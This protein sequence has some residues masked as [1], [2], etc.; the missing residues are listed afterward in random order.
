MLVDTGKKEQDRMYLA[1]GGIAKDGYTKCPFCCHELV[2][3]PQVRNGL[4]HE[5]NEE[6]N[7]VYDTKKSEYAIQLQLNGG[8]VPA[9]ARKPTK[10]AQEQLV[11]VC[12][13]AQQNCCGNPNGLGCAVKCKDKDGNTMCHD[14]KCTCEI[15][16][17]QCAAT[18]DIAKVREIGLL[19]M[20]RN[21][22]A[23][24]QEERDAA[25]LRDAL[26][27]E[28]S[29]AGLA[30]ELHAHTKVAITSA[31]TAGIKAGTLKHSKDVSRV[32]EQAVSNAFAASGRSFS[33]EL[34]AGRHPNLVARARQ[35]FPLPS[36]IVATSDGKLL[37][38][39]N[40]RNSRKR[41]HRHANNGLTTMP[42]AK[43]PARPSKPIPLH[44]IEPST[45]ATGHGARVVSPNE[46]SSFDYMSAKYPG[47]TDALKTPINKSTE[48]EQMQL[49]IWQSSLP[50]QGGKPSAKAAPEELLPPNVKRES[51]VTDLVQRTRRRSMYQAMNDRVVLNLEDSTMETPIETQAAMQR[52]QS[53]A[54]PEGRNMLHDVV[55]ALVTNA[56]D[57][58]EEIPGSQDVITQWDGMWG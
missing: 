22:Q 16:R 21:G 25:G 37:D 24:S 7:R 23:M 33:Q 3:Y 29:V 1:D 45:P 14:G 43:M 38:T 19:I 39:R 36:T 35:E 10:P 8:Q 4:A 11:L 17:C 30:S 57:S 12:H 31:I 51:V 58:N 48:D 34:S 15:C 46:A 18:Y 42:V 6:A 13:C 41:N 20:Q 32:T 26:S 54:T 9:G 40:L 50:H 52:T 5:K 27:C 28:Q 2:D 49:A 55:D 53:F 47:C 56:M 44:G